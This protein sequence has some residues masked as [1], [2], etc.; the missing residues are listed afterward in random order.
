MSRTQAAPMRSSCLQWYGTVDA[1][2]IGGTRVMQPV[3]VLNRAQQIVD[4]AGRRLT[5]CKIERF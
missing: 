2:S 5:G 4:A 1:A 3:T